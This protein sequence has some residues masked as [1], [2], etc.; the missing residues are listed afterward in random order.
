MREYGLPFTIEGVLKRAAL[1]IDKIALNLRTGVLYDDGCLS[2]IAGRTIS[3]DPYRP[4]LDAIHAGRILM[5]QQKTGYALDPSALA[6]VKKVCSN[7][8]KPDIYE[9]SQEVR[10]KYPQLVRPVLEEILKY[11]EPK[12]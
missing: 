12:V 3:Y 9:I 5:Y 1:S 10:K 11:G 4:F 8:S 6:H 7:I 2:A